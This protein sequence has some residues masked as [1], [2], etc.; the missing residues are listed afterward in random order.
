MSFPPQCTAK[1]GGQEIRK[2]DVVYP[3]TGA[4]PGWY[5]V[6]VSVTTTPLRSLGN[7]SSCF[8]KHGILLLE[9]LELALLELELLHGCSPL[10]RLDLSHCQCI[11]GLRTS[12]WSGA[13]ELLCWATIAFALGDVAAITLLPISKV[14]GRLAIPLAEIAE[15][16]NGTPDGASSF[17]SKKCE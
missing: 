3:S 11:F 6:E 17:H 12:G 7:A 4:F 5:L 14:E 2:R 10:L 16:V 1:W 9:V 13:C 15:P 8:F